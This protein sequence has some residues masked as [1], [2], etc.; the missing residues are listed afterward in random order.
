M[1]AANIAE[2]TNTGSPKGLDKAYQDVAWLRKSIKEN[3]LELEKWEHPDG[4]YFHEL[5]KLQHRLYNAGSIKEMK[6]VRKKI[7]YYEALGRKLDETNPPEESI[8]R[9]EKELDELN[10][11]LDEARETI[12]EFVN[13]D[14]ARDDYDDDDDEALSLA[15]VDDVG[16]KTLVDDVYKTLIDVS[17][18]FDKALESHL[19]GVNL[20][21]HLSFQWKAAGNDDSTYAC[22]STYASSQ[23]SGK[24][25]NNSKLPK[26][27]W[28][29]GA[30]QYWFKVSRDDKTV[31]CDDCD[32]DDTKSSTDD[33]KSS[34]DD[35]KSS[36]DDSSFVTRRTAG[37]IESRF[38]EKWLQRFSTFE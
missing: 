7:F 12:L 20:D 14:E 10:K 17:E 38:S 31:F 36:T 32:S 3:E 35:T 16:K 9:L 27:W 18:T 25:K 1:A 30:L 19:D 26:K 29:H 28:K 22:D 34:T 5:E 21:L 24:E 8:A 2:R 4:Y 15:T 33:T 37:T 23:P 11:K 6:Q 13:D